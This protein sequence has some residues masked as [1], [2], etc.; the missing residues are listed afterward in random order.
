MSSESPHPPRRPS[1]A[2]TSDNGSG[3]RS[4]PRR[5]SGATGRLGEDVAAEWLERSGYRILERN[6]RCSGGEID[7]VAI[8]SDI[9]VFVEVKMRSRWDH[10]RASEAVTLKK[11][12]RIA[13]AASLYAASHGLAEHVLRFDTIEVTLS[14]RS[15]APVLNHIEH[16][17][18]P[19]GEYQAL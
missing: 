13:R 2:N 15:S 11:Q 6:W 5:T 18:N 16:A 1:P 14:R 9:V 17:F 12:I 10:G 8:R 7:I 4:A 3:K 19:P